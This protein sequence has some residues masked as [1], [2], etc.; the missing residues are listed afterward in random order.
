MKRIEIRGWSVALIWVGITTNLLVAAPDELNFA[1]EPLA[2]GL[3]E[4]AV[5]RLRSLLNTHPPAEQTAAATE[6]LGEAL[7]AAER[8]GE[9]LK[10]LGDPAIGNPSNARFFRA[11][12]LAGLARWSKA[13]SAYQQV[14]DEPG[15]DYHAEALLGKAE[16]LRALGRRDEAM[17]TL[18]SLSPFPKWDVAA[19]LLSTELLIDKG[20]A[21]AARR[22]L[23]STETEST[24]ERKQRRLLRGRLAALLNNREQAIE[25]FESILRRPEGASH[26]VLLAAIVAL[27]ETHLALHAPEAGDDLLEEFIEHHPN[28]PALPLLFARLDQCYRAERKPARRELARWANDPAQ[29]RRGFAQWYLARM[30]LR[31]GRRDN[32]LQIFADLAGHPATHP[33]LAEALLE[34]AQ[35]QLED[36]QPDRAIATLRIARDLNPPAPL[37][38]RLEFQIGKAQYNAR[39]FEPAADVFERLGRTGAPRETDALF[40]ASVSS[41]RS[42]NRVRFVNDAREFSERNGDED[43]RAELAFQEGMTEAAQGDRKAVTSLRG[44]IRDFP[45]SRKVAEAWVALA[46][47]AFHATPPRLDETLAALAEFAKVPPTE[48]ATERADYLEV[49]LAETDAQ[50]ADTKVIRLANE[51][52]RKHPSS[53]FL[54]DVRMKLAEACYGRQDFAAAQTQ[55]EI[56]S[57]Q[58]PDSEFTEK[59]LFFAAESAMRTM[60]THAFDRALVLFDQVAAWTGELRWPAR[61][62][63]AVIE[64]KLGKTQEA[65]TLYDEVLKSDAKAADKREALCGK[66]DILLEMAATAP[67]NYGRAGEL[68]DQ[69]AAAGDAPSHWRNQAL[70]KKGICLERMSDRAHALETFYR[71]VEGESIPGRTSEFFWFYK[72]GFNAA[73]LLEDDAKWESAAAIY[74]KLASAGGARSEEAAERLSRLR[75]EHFLWQ[76]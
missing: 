66:G 12:T 19:R 68:F 53:S 25:L 58:T 28:D 49:W 35:L 38:A 30:E 24:G 41:L 48:V 23:E 14:L 11:Q 67:E 15:S 36:N 1:L 3:S 72:A 65:I 7:F 39:R 57:Q 70:F 47:L 4:I 8:F 60:A 61:N 64:R 18:R 32:A 10:I 33:S 40:N 50:D 37:V 46:E 26:A 45:K 75:L 55:F 16:A 6:K 51:F 56:L 20:D 42:N 2:Q 9:A 5:T 74:Q 69:L 63:Q 52:L 27:T 43:G 21:T 31:A 62:E 44:F 59:A 17:E 76:H 34:F 29:P 22:L 54:A 73:R 13:L 71:V